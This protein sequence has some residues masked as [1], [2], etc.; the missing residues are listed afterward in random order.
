MVLG[1]KPQFVPKILD[2][3]KIHTLRADPHR[4]WK[5]GRSIQF[6]TGVRTKHYKTFREDGNCIHTHSIFLSPESKGACLLDSKM[7]T[8][9]VSQLSKNDGFESV[10]E[11][12]K[13]FN[14]PQIRMCIHWTNFKYKRG[15]TASNKLYYS[16]LNFMEVVQSPGALASLLIVTKSKLT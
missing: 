13:W 1:F 2:G 9:S 5:P 7:S 4:R 11:F 10:D 6:A 14:V 3:T 15:R 16:Y 12:W 8:I